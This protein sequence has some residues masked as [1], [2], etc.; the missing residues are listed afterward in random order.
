MIFLFIHGFFNNVLIYLDCIPSNVDNQLLMKWIIC[1]WK[2]SRTDFEYHRRI[3]L[4]TRSIMKTLGSVADQW[5]DT[6]TKDTLTIN[7]ECQSS[8]CHESQLLELFRDLAN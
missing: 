8:D 3:S 1:E 4:E 6:G 7:T 2:C 5:A